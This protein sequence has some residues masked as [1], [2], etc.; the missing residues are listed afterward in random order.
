MRVSRRAAIVIANM[1]GTGVFT[2]LGFQLLEIRSAPVLLALWAVGGLAALCGALSYAE[3]GAALPRSGGE[4]HFLT[5]IYHPMP[6][7]LG[8]G[9]GYGGLRRADRTG[10]YD[11]RQLLERRVPAAVSRSGWRRG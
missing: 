9:V 5:E 6:V 7:Y 3:L 1:I 11:L 8:L 10:S 2:S 4:Y